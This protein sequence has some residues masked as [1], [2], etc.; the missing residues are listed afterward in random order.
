MYP[1]RTFDVGIAEGH[2][3]TFAGGLAK[4]GMK[5]VVTIYSSFLQRAYD[6]IIIDVCLQNLPVVFAIDRAGLVGADGETHHGIFD[7]SFLSQ[8]PNMTILAPRDGKE[9]EEMLEYALTL[10]SPCAIRYPRGESINF[11]DEIEP[12]STGPQNM[13]NGG[14]VHIYAV[15]NMV[16]N[17]L[18]ASDI[19]SEYGI[20]CQVIN[21]RI[22]KPLPGDTIDMSIREARLIVTLEDNIVS[23]GFG[24]AVSAYCAKK[25]SGVKVVNMGIED[26]FVEHG[27]VAELQNIKKLDATSI[28]ERIKNIIERKA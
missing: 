13:K 19:L 15:G 21:T 3:V 5:P 27:T 7:I 6:Q 28:A 24:S 2:A 14:N 26:A 11:D 16:K 1:N 25:Y 18:K 20:D 22:I 17:A 23:G 8:I 12:I 10:E 9:L 4:G